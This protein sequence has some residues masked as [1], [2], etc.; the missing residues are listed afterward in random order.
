MTISDAYNFSLLLAQFHILSMAL[1][2]SVT[3]LKDP[4]QCCFTGKLKKAVIYDLYL[5]CPRKTGFS[6]SGAEHWKGI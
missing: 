4:K 2:S 6:S 5:R 1:E 3:D